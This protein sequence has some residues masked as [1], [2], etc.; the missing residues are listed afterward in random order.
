MS[1]HRIMFMATVAAL[2][3]NTAHSQIAASASANAESDKKT[4]YEMSADGAV[5]IAPD[6]HVSDYKL[7][8][9]LQP[10]V[11]ALVK[12]AV[13]GWQ[14]E[15][16]VV[17]GKAVVAKT[18]MHL[19][20]RAE[21]VEGKDDQFSVHIDSINFGNPVRLDIGKLPHYPRAASG[22]RLGAY[23]VL[24][25]R[26][27]ESGKVA[28]VY[29]YQT[30]LD[31]RASNEKQ[32]EK[33]RR[34]F[35]TAAISAAKTWQYDLTEIVGGR[36]SGAYVVIPVRF[37][38][39]PSRTNRNEK[40]RGYEAGPIHPAPWA[41]NQGQP[42]LAQAGDGATSTSSHFHLKDDVIGKAL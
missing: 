11:A 8:G 4:F 41:A 2:A 21:P 20:L 31:A 36:A 9:S 5:Q 12:R 18:A 27:D 10:A 22:A 34:E 23:V 3:A 17:D 19:G 38:T 28:E 42:L 37:L 7:D 1:M 32:A 25:G 15:P 40:W 6:G 29:P 33:W 24:S 35:E 14:F 16:I 30:S 13:L 26:L 39:S